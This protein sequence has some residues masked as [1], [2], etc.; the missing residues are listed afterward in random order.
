M[1]ENMASKLKR[2]LSAKNV[3]AIILFGAIVLVFV[4]FGLPN[5]MTGGFGA[6]ARVNESFI[7]FTDF[8]QASE[9]MEQMYSQYMGGRSFDPQQ[10]KLM[11]QQALERLI[12]DE[13]TAQSARRAGIRATD[14]EIRN[15]ITK[16]IP[17]FQ[18]DGRFMREYY[19]GYLSSQGMSA[20]EFE[21]RVRKQ[22][23]S[24]RLRRLFEASSLTLGLESEKQRTL[25]NYKMNLQFAK[26]DEE[27]ADSINVSSSEVDAALA[28][29]DFVK[30]V[31]TQFDLQKPQLSQQEQVRAQHI[32]IMANAGDAAAE[33]KALAQIQDLKAK[34]AKEDFGKLAKAHSQDPGSKA[35]NGD[36]GFFGRGAMV[37]EFDQVAFSAPVG[38]VSEPVK[39]QFGYHLIKV[40]DKK[41]AKEAKFEDHR[42]QLA[43]QILAREKVQKK[44][45]ELEN[46]V[47]K[48]PADAEAE[49]RS[50]GLK[51]DETGFFNLAADSIPK[52]P[53]LD[54]EKIT[55]L[56]PKQPWMKSL[57][58]A[59]SARYLIKLKEVK[60][61]NSNP[62]ANSLEMV[63]RRR[64]DGIFMSWLED[65][66]KRSDIE[67]NEIIFR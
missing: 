56:T 65:F 58:R 57:V 31:Q 40:T 35:K 18:K 38:K 54:T 47:A 37:K 46:V 21:A 10:R 22:L 55:E 5:Q 9:Q 30:R 17:A 52:I 59:G 63:Q 12:Y 53:G 16:E 43:R 20:G 32:L 24:Q 33:K 4:F 61:D 7:T 66:R 60:K 49:V 34:T 28:K 51:W 19:M 13:L 29:P 64:T 3:T 11:Q 1:S 44:A 2:K 39:T 23:E 41:P 6:A 25:Q 67:T 48:N 62:D 45:Q 27:N 8:Q 14:I 15:I 36:L 42:S 50:L 26:L